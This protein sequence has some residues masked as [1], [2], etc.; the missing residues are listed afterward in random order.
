MLFVLVS[1]LNS[2]A[3]FDDDDNDDGDGD[4]DGD[5]DDDDYDENHDL[6]PPVNVVQE[7]ENAEHGHIKAFFNLKIF[8]Y[9]FAIYFVKFV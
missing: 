4:G 6:S 2:Q 3:M 9:F 8:I 7:R 5:G 1:A